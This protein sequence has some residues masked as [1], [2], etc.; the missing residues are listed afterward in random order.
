MFFRGLPDKLAYEWSGGQF[1]AKPGSGNHPVFSSKPLPDGTGFRVCPCSSKRP[2]DEK[3]FRFIR[4]GCR[5]LHT[6]YTMDRNSYL[7]EKIR[8]NIP[9]TLA[10][11]LRFLGEVPEECI[12]HEQRV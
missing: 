10:H 3:S 1:P 11:R 12:R 5:L 4:K 2:F 8:L 7:I 6:G 9:R